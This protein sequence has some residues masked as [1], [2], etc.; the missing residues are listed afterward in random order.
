M[1]RNYYL[2]ITLL[3][4]TIFGS[5]DGLAGLVDVEVRFDENKLPYLNGRTLKGMLVMECADILAA[6]RTANN[7]EK[8]TRS[9]A[10]LFG[11][12]GNTDWDHPAILSIG[13]AQL[14]ESFRLGIVRDIE[15]NRLTS[16]DVFS[17]MTTIRRQTAMEDSGVPKEHSLRS[18]RLI[19]RSLI[20]ES[21]LYF[22]E[23]PEEPDLALLA[24]CIK[25]FRRCGT[26]RNRGSGKIQARILDENLIDITQQQIKV[27]A[28]EVNQ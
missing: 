4:D 1:S 19:L 8:W 10:R 26:N 25:S 3:S 2:Q 24:A 28:R 14:P 23:E 27:F 21:H 13:T 5:G 20:F 11:I 22:N 15:T 16:D 7:P 9:A 12:P 18:S 17:A 6:I